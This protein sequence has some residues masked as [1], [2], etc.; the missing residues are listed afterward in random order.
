MER[1]ECYE[2]GADEQPEVYLLSG[3]L[4]GGC[5]S[6]NHLNVI[7]ASHRFNRRGRK[8]DEVLLKLYRSAAQ[9]PLSKRIAGMKGVLYMHRHDLKLTKG[10]PQ[11]DDA[12][13]DDSA[14]V[15]ELRREQTREPSVKQRPTRRNTARTGGNNKLAEAVAPVR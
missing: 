13:H 12:A 4:R 2:R 6:A 15:A 14:A 7:S 10:L 1:R 11:Y 3:R 8:A 9:F 5:G